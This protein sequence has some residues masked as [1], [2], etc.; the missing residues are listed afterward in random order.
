[1]EEPAMRSTRI[2]ATGAA[3]LA[4]VLGA[5]SGSTTSGTGQ[6]A[7]A[8]TVAPA[9]TG[10][11]TVPF[12]GVVM[13]KELLGTWIADVRQPGPSTGLWRLRVTEHLMELKNPAAASDA[14]YFWLWTDKID[15]KTFH[16][17]ADADCPAAT[18]S[19]ALQAGQ[20]VMTSTD[21]TSKN[22]PCSDRHVVLTTPFKL[23]S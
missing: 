14:D 17:A 20:L 15:G 7:P 1:M 22:T 5:C 9:S 3:I 2:I 10:P 16:M 8:A 12:P 13:P 4:L 6:Q 18:Y 11:T 23:D 19:W 21:D